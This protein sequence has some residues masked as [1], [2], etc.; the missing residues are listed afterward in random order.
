MKLMGS[1][2]MKSKPKTNRIVRRA[3]MFFKKYTTECIV[4]FSFT[5]VLVFTVIVMLLSCKYIAIPD[6]L[7]EWFYKFFGLELLALSG[8]KVSKHVGSAFGK[9]EEAVDGV[10]YD[11]D[12]EETTDSCETE[13]ESEE[14]G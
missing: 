1:G 9:I 2:R 5:I 4:V 7:I 10:V 11:A 13:T 8:I 6:I 14:L 3:W 12:E